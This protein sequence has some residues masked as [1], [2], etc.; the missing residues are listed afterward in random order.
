MPHNHNMSG[1]DQSENVGCVSKSF[2]FPGWLVT[3]NYQNYQKIYKRQKNGSNNNVKNGFSDNFLKS[4]RSR[5]GKRN[6]R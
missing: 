2:L 5:M 1:S 4:I 6:P 3:P